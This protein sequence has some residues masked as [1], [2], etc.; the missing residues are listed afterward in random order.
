MM[1][2]YNEFSEWLHV[3]VAAFTLGTF[4]VFTLILIPD[5]IDSNIIETSSTAS[6]D[7]IDG[8]KIFSSKGCVVC[9]Q[10]V[11]S[12]IAPS[13]VGIYGTER[14][15]ASGQSVLADEDYIRESILW[16]TAKVSR[17]Y[18]AS[19]PGYNDA[20]TSDEVDKMIAYIKSL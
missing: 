3:S 6:V 4:A 11:S 18:A 14:K 2:I 13:L 5:P 17:G 10:S 15:L 20:F 16:S 12:S 19:M 1:N 7:A 9:H 8:K